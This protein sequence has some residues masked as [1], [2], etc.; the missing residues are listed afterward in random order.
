MKLLRRVEALQHF[1]AT[2]RSDLEVLSMSDRGRLRVKSL[3]AEI[4]SV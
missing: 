3:A 4:D 2:Y 1:A